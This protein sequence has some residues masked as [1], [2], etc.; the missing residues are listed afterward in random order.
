VSKATAQPVIVT[1]TDN[2]QTVLIWPAVQTQKVPPIGLSMA[3]DDQ[4]IVIVPAQ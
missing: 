4:T 3:G 1:M 2:S